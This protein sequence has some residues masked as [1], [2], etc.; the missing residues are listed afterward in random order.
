MDEF[1]FITVK[2]VG[3]Q[4]PTEKHYKIWLNR[5]HSHI[6]NDRLIDILDQ[7]YEYGTFNRLHMHLLVCTHGAQNFNFLYDMFKSNWHV[8]VRH[9][10]DEN[11][12][13]K[14]SN[15]MEKE[16]PQQNY[17]LQMEYPFQ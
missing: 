17:K 1:Y 16:K 4:L 12:L 10:Q 2:R 7:C 9:V 6:G 8:D 14:I 15:Y 13:P 5:F 3:K 11:D